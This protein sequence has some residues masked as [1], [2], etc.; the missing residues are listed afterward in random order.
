VRLR[1]V[2]ARL[3]LVQTNV[4]SPQEDTLQ[5]Q[6]RLSAVEEDFQ[7]SLMKLSALEDRLAQLSGDN[8]MSRLSLATTERHTSE[9]TSTEPN[10]PISLDLPMINSR[11]CQAEATLEKQEATLNILCSQLN[12]NNLRSAFSYMGQPSRSCGC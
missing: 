9:P 7:Q 3:N 2:E 12:K 10:Q 5:V 1:A 4:L 8:D 11:L 6:A